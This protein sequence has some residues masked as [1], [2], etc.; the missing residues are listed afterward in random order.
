[1]GKYTKGLIAVSHDDFCGHYDLMIGD[2]SVG[3]I[4]YADNQSGGR[5]EADAYHMAACWNACE[6]LADPSVVPELVK[7]LNEILQILRHNPNAA[8]P[9]RYRNARASKIAAAALA[10]AKGDAA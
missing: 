7:A 9:P 6:G 10:K 8:E 4:F 1:M 3:M 5:G 2:E